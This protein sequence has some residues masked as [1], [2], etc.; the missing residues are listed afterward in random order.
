MKNTHYK[1]NS[2]VNRLEKDRKALANHP[3]V[4][5]NNEIRINEKFIAEELEHLEKKR[6]KNKKHRLNA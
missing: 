1:I 6:A 2:K 4:D 5:T 3:D